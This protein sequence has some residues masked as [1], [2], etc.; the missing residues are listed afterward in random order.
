MIERLGHVLYWLG[1]GFAVLMWLVGA[2]VWVVGVFALGRDALEGVTAV[3]L[4]AA[5]IGLLSWLVGR[6]CLYILSAR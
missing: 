5:L 4:P 3:G 2:G 6:A 1:T